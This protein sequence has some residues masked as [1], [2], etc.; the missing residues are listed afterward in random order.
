M[1]D[2]LSK[3]VLE[4][5]VARLQTEND[6]LLNLLNRP[7]S[8]TVQSSDSGVMQQIAQYLPQ[9]THIATNLAHVASA[10]QQQNESLKAVANAL[11]DAQVI[12]MPSDRQAP[13]NGPKGPSWFS[14]GASNTPWRRP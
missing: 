12:K 11:S 4:S 5:E 14:D 13:K 10:V 1:S 9:L 7:V 6:R 8:V 3:Q 2:D